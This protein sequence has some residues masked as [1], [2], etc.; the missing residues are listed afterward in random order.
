MVMLFHNVVFK[1]NLRIRWRHYGGITP[2]APPPPHPFLRQA[3]EQIF[4]DYV[5]G[6][7]A[8]SDI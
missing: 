7:S 8:T 3:S 4:K 2:P 6:F 5:N 1:L